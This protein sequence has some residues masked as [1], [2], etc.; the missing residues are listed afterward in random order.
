MGRLMHSLHL[1]K[2]RHTQSQILDRYVCTHFHVICLYA[3]MCVFMNVNKYVMERT[4]GPKVCIM[5]SVSWTRQMDKRA[6]IS[7]V[8]SL[9]GPGVNNPEANT[10]KY[11]EEVAVNSAR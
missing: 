1:Y 5:C 7:V 4:R 9:S 3:C 11:L 2:H 8:P 10:L 6:V